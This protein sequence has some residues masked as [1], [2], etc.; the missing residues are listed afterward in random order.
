MLKKTL[1]LLFSFAL[2]FAIGFGTVM[3]TP[4]VVQAGPGQC[5]HH[6]CDGGGT[7]GCRL[8]LSCVPIAGEAGLWWHA[9]GDI[10]CT[11]GLS[12]FEGGGSPC[13]C[14]LM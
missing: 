6:D 5:T 9:P 2:F 7:P 10:D 1:L 8:N 13:N 3:M 14:T 12:C 4:I 11:G